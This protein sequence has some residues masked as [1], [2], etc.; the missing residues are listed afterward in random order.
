MKKSE[1]VQ[2]PCYFDK[3]IDLVDDIDIIDAIDNSVDEIKALD[4][5]TL[6]AIGDRVYEPG[7]WTIKD[8]FRHLI[9]TEH[10]LTYRA[11][12]FAR[13]DPTELPGFD[14]DLFAANVD[15]SKQSIDEVID[16]LVQRH[17]TTRSMFSSFS[18]EG[19]QNLGTSSGIRM[20]AL[21]FGFAV[22]G[23]QKYHL[24]I[25]K[26]RYFPLAN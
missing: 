2:P 9:D 3:Y 12:R 1:I 24:N 5:A 15:T 7:K 25:V 8:V 23:H 21:A 13:L 16:E 4:I 10:V 26:D 19:L 18:D 14:Q 22:V 20:S 11:L 6:N 17:R